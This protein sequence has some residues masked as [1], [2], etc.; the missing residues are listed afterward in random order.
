MTVQEAVERLKAAGLYIEAREIRRAC[1]ANNIAGKRPDGKNRDVWAIS[2]SELEQ[3]KIIFRGGKGEACQEQQ[4][5]VHQEQQEQE[6]VLKLKPDSVTIS[7]N[8]PTSSNSKTGNTG[9]LLGVLTLILVVMMVVGHLE[10]AKLN[11]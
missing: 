9:L 3:L 4:E 1:R 2:D 11:R 8:M 6:P 5:Q 7:G 10:R